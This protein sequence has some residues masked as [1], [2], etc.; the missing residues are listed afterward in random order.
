MKK[1][2][3]IG[4]NFALLGFAVLFLELVFGNWLQQ[5]PAKRIPEISR[6][7]G[8]THSFRTYGLTGE[9]VLVNFTRNEQGFRGQGNAANSRQILVVGGST[10]IEY[11]V[12]ESLTWAEQLQ[13]GLNK[14]LSQ[15]SRYEFDVINAGVA[16]QTL[17]GNQFSIDLWL[18]HIKNLNPEFVIVYYGHNDAIYSLGKDNNAIIS[19]PDSKSIGVRE[20]VLTSSALVML[21]REIKG[22]LDSWALN[23]NNLFDYVEGGLPVDGEIFTRGQSHARIANSSYSDKLNNLIWSIHRAWPIAKIIFVAQSN[24]NCYFLDHYSYHSYSKNRICEDL[25]AVHS[26]TKSTILSMNSDLSGKLFYEPLFMD[27]PYDRSGSSDAIHTNSR[28]SKGIADKLTTRLRK[29]L[30]F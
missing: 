18:K 3:L 28:G 6:Q 24:P 17:L 25:L 14:T 4:V 15:S 13:Q 26:Y 30:V 10:A 21:L 29:Y 22:N 27:N 19:D 1:I 11:V 16:G 20:W 8:R 7:A 12:P 9:D 5:N 2:K 23:N